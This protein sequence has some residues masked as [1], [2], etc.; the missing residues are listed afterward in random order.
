MFSKT[1]I[2][3]LLKKI[4]ALFKVIEYAGDR[5][6]PGISGAEVDS[7]HCPNAFP[8]VVVGKRSAGNEKY[9]AQ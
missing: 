5:C 1:E 8:L 4:K 3:I 6:L 7:Y 9:H 2:L